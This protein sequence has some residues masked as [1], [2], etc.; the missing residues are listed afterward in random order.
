MLNISEEP[1]RIEFLKG[2]AAQAAGD[3]SARL[4]RYTIARAEY[5]QA[6]AAYDSVDKTFP[7]FVEA[8]NHKQ[9]VQ[10]I[11]AKLPLENKPE[12]SPLLFDPLFVLGQW[13]QNQ[14]DKAKKAGWLPPEEIVGKKALKK[15]N[16]TDKKI[17]R[18]KQINLGANQ[19]V[20]LVIELNET[21][22][23]KIRLVIQ[24]LPIGD[25][26]YLPDNL[27]FVVIPKSG[28]PDEYLTEHHNPGFE[29]ECFYK[30]DEQFTVKM[31]LNDIIVTEHFVI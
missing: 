14:F 7:D 21:K 8:Q 16:V 18:A 11:L 22:N 1:K 17:R 31:Q 10:K 3:Y 20:A 28:K 19:I 5:Q 15:H 13:L 30:H 4:G 12:Q 23:Q 24:V 2:K 26:T 25:Q 29:T 9:M 27:Q 6:I